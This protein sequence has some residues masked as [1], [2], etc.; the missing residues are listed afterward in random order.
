[1]EYRK[2]IF[3]KISILVCAGFGGVLISLNT[4]LSIFLGICLFIVA[5]VL[6][7]WFDKNK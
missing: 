6:M 1:M 5:S 3:Y 7:E 4:G 2:E